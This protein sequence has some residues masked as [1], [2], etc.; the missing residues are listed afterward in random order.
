M[1]KLER[2]DNVRHNKKRQIAS[3]LVVTVFIRLMVRNICILQ[4]ERRGLIHKT[5]AKNAGEGILCA[6]GERNLGFYGKFI[7]SFLTTE[8]D[9]QTLLRHP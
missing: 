3:L 7:L 5:K 2:N 8:S 6:R 1:A 9:N 4:S